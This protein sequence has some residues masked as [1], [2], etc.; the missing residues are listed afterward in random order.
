MEEEEEEEGR[1]SSILL[2]GLKRAAG[3]GGRSGEI[4]G[5]WE[6]EKEGGAA[7]EK[8]KNRQFSQNVNIRNVFLG[9]NFFVDFHC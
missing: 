7:T 2:F 9:Y 3:G 5:D 4:C 6:E 1:T 8:C